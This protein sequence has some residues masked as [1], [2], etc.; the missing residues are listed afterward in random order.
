MST[1]LLPVVAVGSSSVMQPLLANLAIWNLANVAN[2][3][4]SNLANVANL[5]V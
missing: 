3:T 2:L 4:V 1:P 5:T